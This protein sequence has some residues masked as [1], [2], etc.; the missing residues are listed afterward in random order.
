MCVCVHVRLI[1]MLVMLVI[2]CVIA[3][4]RVC[5]YVRAEGDGWVDVCICLP[6]APRHHL[7]P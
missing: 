4:V 6:A 5:F 3:C 1:V 7:Q 2:A